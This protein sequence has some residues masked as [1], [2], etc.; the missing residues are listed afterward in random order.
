MCKL[1][2]VSGEPEA[3][4]Q[5]AQN[6]EGTGKEY[7]GVQRLFGNEWLLSRILNGSGSVG[8]TG[9]RAPQAEG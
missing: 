8:E 3:L 1:P 9:G 2:T 6:T 5:C 4:T 7:P